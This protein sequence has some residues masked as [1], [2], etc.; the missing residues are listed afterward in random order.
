MIFIFCYLLSIKINKFFK[1]SFFHEQ[2][3]VWLTKKFYS[4]ISTSVL[5]TKIDKIAKQE[6][7]VYFLI[8]YLHKALCFKRK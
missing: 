6:K 1:K 7:N 3:K 2:Y 5:F 8:K 4:A